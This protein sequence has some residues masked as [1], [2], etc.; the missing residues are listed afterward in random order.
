MNDGARVSKLISYLHNDMGENQTSFRTARLVR[1]MM[2]RSRKRGM[3]FL[4][5]R[6]ERRFELT[7]HASRKRVEISHIVLSERPW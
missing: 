7:F 5:F 3:P 6:V 2:V 4:F 1:G